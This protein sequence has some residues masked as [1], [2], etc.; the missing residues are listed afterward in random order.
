MTE[1]KRRIAARSEL[2]ASGVNALAEDAKRTPSS[3]SPRAE[4]PRR[5]KSTR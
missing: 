5:A 4:S 2:Q 3:A 1:G